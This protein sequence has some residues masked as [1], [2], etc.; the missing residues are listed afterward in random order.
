MS[1]QS[2]YR[3]ALYQARALY[4]QQLQD[5]LI[6]ALYLEY[7]NTIDSIHR[8]VRA[9]TI[10]QARASALVESIMREL[11]SLGNRLG[12]EL[13]TAILSATELAAFAQGEAVRA[14]S[15]AAGVTVQYNFT[16]VPA[17]AVEMMM[18]RRDIQGI[19]TTFRTLINRNIQALAPDVD[20]FLTESFTTGKSAVRTAEEL[21]A[22]LARGDD[23]VTEA[24]RELRI[25]PLARTIEELGDIPDLANY[26]NA[27]TLLSDSYRIAVSE[28][29]NAYVE[30]ARQAAAESPVVDLLRFTL[31]G[32][33]AGLRSSPCECDICADIDLHGYGPG[34]Y[35]PDTYPGTQHPF[36][37][38]TPEPTLLRPS[39]WGQERR[40]VPDPKTLTESD[41]RSMLRRKANQYSAKVTDN[42]IRRHVQTVNRNIQ[43]AHEASRAAVGV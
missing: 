16:E 19:A 10:T 23:S 25:H 31:S 8:Q 34:L 26:K 38:C 40:P 9:Q 28:T 37:M 15:R 18:V 11:V 6:R 13:D 24:L 4:Q 33:H 20:R 43:A 42:K 39:Q 1:W 21:A 22:I 30:T 2:E 36:C 32:R 29:N 41:V 27:R 7:A 3:R 5:D 12:F 17:R 14:A 35:H